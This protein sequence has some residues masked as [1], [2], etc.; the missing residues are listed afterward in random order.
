MFTKILCVCS[1]LSQEID[2]LQEIYIDELQ[3]ETDTRLC[4]YIILI[5]NFY[6]G[7]SSAVANQSMGELH[8]HTNSSPSPPF[9]TAIC[10]HP[11]PFTLKILPIT[12][13][14]DVSPHLMNMH[15]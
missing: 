14:T 7:G 4:S 1:E 10:S 15:H 11:H 12:A 13:V 6:S 3:I 9:F 8:I 5:T 2:I